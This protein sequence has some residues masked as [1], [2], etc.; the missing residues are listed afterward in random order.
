MNCVFAKY[1]LLLYSLNPEF[2]QENIKNCMVISHFATASGGRTPMPHRGFARGPTGG[3][4]D[5]QAW[6]SPYEPLHCEILGTPVVLT[7][8]VD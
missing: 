4:P 7:I 8:N 5:P 6:P 3:L 2:L 1:T